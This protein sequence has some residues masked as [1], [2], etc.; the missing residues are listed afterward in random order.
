MVIHEP[1]TKEQEQMDK[2]DAD[3][4]PQ[5]SNTCGTSVVTLDRFVVPECLIIKVLELCHDSPMAGHLGVKRTQDRVS[6]QFW[7][8]GVNDDTVEYCRSC[9]KCMRRNPKHRKEGLLQAQ[10]FEIPEEQIVPMHWIVMDQI[11]MPSLT[12]YG[13]SR[14]ILAIDMTTRFL[15]LKPVKSL[16]SN[17]V[18]FLLNEILQYGNIRKIV[19]DE[20]AYFTSSVLK[21]YCEEKGISL[22]HGCPCRPQVQG[23]AEKC[24]GT[25]KTMISKFSQES[26]SVW[27]RLIPQIAIS[28]NSTV[29]TSSNYSPFF[30][31]FGR[32][33]HIPKVSSL[34][35]PELTP[36]ELRD[37]TPEQF[38]Q[39]MII[40]WKDAL[41]N[42]RKAG[43]DMIKRENKSRIPVT[44]EVGMKVLKE[45]PPQ[46]TNANL[47]TMRWDS[48]P[49]TVTQVLGPNTYEIVDDK[50]RTQVANIS[51]LKRYYLR[52]EIPRLQL[53]LDRKERNEM[54]DEN[55]VNSVRKS[56]Q[57]IKL[58]HGNQ[59]RQPQGNLNSLMK[60]VPE[61]TKK[62]VEKSSR[63]EA[64]QTS[65]KE[66]TVVMYP[67]KTTVNLEHSPPSIH[68][69]SVTKPQSYQLEK[70]VQ[71]VVSRRTSFEAKKLRKLSRTEFMSRKVELKKFEP[72]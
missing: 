68:A 33:Y 5:V 56:I 28:Y 17:E 59:E 8:H 64:D 36:R 2:E 48:G 35:L 60:F 42:L 52:S 53:L 25:V 47:K 27:L 50:G 7:W 37:E 3:L 44:L 34:T 55:L 69:P 62:E 11:E 65:R 15:F 61:G 19:S 71:Q 20:A 72:P 12:T 9:E 70:K 1:K 4:L 13:Y 18:T 16:N 22:R 54:M 67:Q 43:E 30:L 57:I 41:E 58:S 49:F 63:K 39:R 10:I 6:K 24:V 66:G 40:Y 38:R 46:K 45:N 32:Y 29:Q 26:P 51:Q 14:I 23:L 21:K 31:L